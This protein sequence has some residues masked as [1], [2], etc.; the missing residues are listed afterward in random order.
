MPDA[1]V[2]W[3]Q[4]THGSPS[5]VTLGKEK[6]L[7]ISLFVNMKAFTLLKT[8]KLIF[9]FY[10]VILLHCFEF[11]FLLFRIKWIK[12]LKWNNRCSLNWSFHWIICLVLIM[13][14]L[15]NPLPPRKLAVMPLVQSI[16]LMKKKYNDY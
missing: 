4:A 9:V 5:W 1:G 11:S 13:F 3:G 16:L 15:L 10:N 12:F 7:F 2:G 6:L 14:I 8:V